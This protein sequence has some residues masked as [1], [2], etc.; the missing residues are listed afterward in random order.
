MRILVAYDGSEYADAAL[1]DLKRGRIGN[2]VE[3]V[4][5][6]LADVFVPPPIDEE[7]DNTFPLYVPDGVKR[8]HERARH[9]LSETRG[10]A[11]RASEQI[12]L[13][14]PGWQISSEAKAG[15][16]AWELIWKAD[17]WK[18]DLIVRPKK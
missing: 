17:S 5:M 9:A 15:S 13:L 11:K 16:P 1:E 4:V 18:P 10:L 12:R 6:T 8:A 7:V 14:F 2:R 3:V